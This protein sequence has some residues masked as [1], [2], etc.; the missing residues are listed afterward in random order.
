MIRTGEKSQSYGCQYYGCNNTHKMAD[1]N[2]TQGVLKE[3]R[4]NTTI[5]ARKDLEK[6]SQKTHKETTKAKCI[7]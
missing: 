4:K 5:V 2:R 6:V 1:K 7:C 3:V